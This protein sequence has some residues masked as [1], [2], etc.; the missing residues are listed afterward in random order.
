MPGI[1]T[2][3][4]LGQ[5]TVSGQ[6]PSSEGKQAGLEVQ[7]DLG[8]APCGHN[9]HWPITYLYEAL[10][11]ILGGRMEQEF[12]V[13][14]PACYEWGGCTQCHLPQLPTGAETGQIWA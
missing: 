1:P 8:Q 12:P 10:L 5:R 13:W 4:Q 2:T 3:Y 7:A 9:T 14:E 11:G 6:P